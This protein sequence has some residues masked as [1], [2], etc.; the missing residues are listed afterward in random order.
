MIKIIAQNGQVAYDV[1]EYIVDTYEDIETI[2][3]RA[4][5]GSTA[6][7]IE[8]SEV[9]IKNTSGEWIKLE[10]SSGGSGQPTITEDMLI[11]DNEIT[12]ICK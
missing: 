3:A 10:S 1:Y 5:A 7:V 11:T 2:P 9:Y 6:L 4:G 8:S 12:D